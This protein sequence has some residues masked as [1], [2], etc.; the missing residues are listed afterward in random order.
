MMKAFQI[1]TGIRQFADIIECVGTYAPAAEDLILTNEYIYEPLLGSYDLPCRTVFLERY[2]T[3]EP[4]DEMVDAVLSDLADT[5][6][7]RLFAIGG[8]TIIDVAKVLAVAGGMDRMDDLYDAMPDLTKRHPLIILPTTCGTGSEVTNISVISRVKKGVKQGLVSPAMYADEAALVTQALLTLPY[9]VFATSSIDAMIHAVESFLSPNAC[10]MS[11]LFSEKALRMIVSSW[12]RMMAEGGG[13]AW[14][15]YAQDFLLA[16]DYAGI[17]FGYAGCA[18]VHALSYPV[19]STHHVTHGQS[20]QMLFADVMRKY[21][22]KKPIGKL[23]RLEEILAGVLDVE[24]VF[25]LMALY[26]L[27]DTVFKKDRLSEHGMT[28]EEIR[29]FSKNVLETQQRLLNNNYVELSYDDIVEIYT[30]AF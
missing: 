10:A 15:K 21:Q 11:E 3:G 23:N 1:L 14:L 5:S 9:P 18:A 2:G 16:S 22:E 4:T 28:T 6:Y 19:G 25:A 7:A 13:D 17:A 27:M 20:N 26:D 29:I 12:K 24:A 30:K 8:G